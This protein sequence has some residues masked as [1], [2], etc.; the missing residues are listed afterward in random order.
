MLSGL[1]GAPV[2]VDI[3]LNDEDCVKLPIADREGNVETYAM[4]PGKTPVTGVVSIKLKGKASK[5]DH[6]GITLELIGQIELLY[7]RGN[8]YEFL[9]LSKPLEQPGQLTESKEYKFAFGDVEKNYESYNGANVVLRYFVRCTI[10]RNYV[11]NVTSKQEFVVFN[12]EEVPEP[13]DG[14]KQEVGIEDCLH[15]EFEYNKSKYDLNDVVIGKIDFLLVGFKIK[16][17][18]IIIIKRESTHGGGPGNVYN[19]SE[20]LAKF[21]IMDGAPVR[22][23]SIPIRLFLKPYRLSPT[24]RNIDNKYSVRYFLN[25]VLID[26]EGRRYFKQQEITLYRTQVPEAPPASSS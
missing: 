10:K 19:D 12:A 13:N 23:E 16:H 14:I 7:D 8:P 1:F 21:E 24:Y 11:A 26:Q 4:F 18:E 22:G 15:I 3:T 17:M 20:N 9:S 2:E 6:Q 25:L 5:M